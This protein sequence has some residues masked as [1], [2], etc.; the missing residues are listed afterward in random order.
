MIVMITIITST[1]AAMYPTTLKNHQAVLLALNHYG[2]GIQAMIEKR[3]PEALVHFHA[4]IQEYDHFAPAYYNLGVLYGQMD[5]LNEALDCIEQAVVVANTEQHWQ[6]FTSANNYLGHL[7]RSKDTYDYTKL[8][9]ALQHFDAALS[10][11]PSDIL[12]VDYVAAMYNKALTLSTLGYQDQAL[13]LLQK[14]LQLNPKHTGAYLQLSHL[15][16]QKQ[17]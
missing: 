9:K 14:V 2:L 1:M 6:T 5:K 3:S 13:Q 15:Y 11:S 16:Y 17:D 7:Y 10:I 12:L 8:S 4:A